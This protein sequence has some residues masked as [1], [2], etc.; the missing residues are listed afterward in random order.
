MESNIILSKESS[1]EEIKS[2]F[3]AVLRLSQDDNEFPINLDE[4]WPLVYSEKSKAVRS[5]K[6][7][8]IEDID[9]QV[10]AQNGENLEEVDYQVLRKN[11]ENSKG[12]RPTN[13][14]HI[15]LS[16]MEFFI[17]RKVRPV[18]E[19]YRQ[20][21]HGV[22]KGQL[23]K[24]VKGDNA[25]G[26]TLEEKLEFISICKDGGFFAWEV[27]GMVGDLF[28][29]IRSLAE[30]RTAVNLINEK[31]IL[32]NR[33]LQIVLSLYAKNSGLPSVRTH[34]E[35]KELE[36]KPQEIKLPPLGTM[37]QRR[38]RVSTGTTVR[39]MTNL[40]R[41][42]GY[43]GIYARE[44][45]EA[46]KDVGFVRRI[47]FNGSKRWEWSLTANG[48][49]FGR[50]TAQRN[51]IAIRPKWLSSKFDGLMQTLGYSK[52]TRKGVQL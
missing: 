19:V 21:F 38:S 50:N 8:F 32:E 39:S 17:A 41:E 47:D 46:L 35:I 22:A 2:Y 1:S 42:R 33:V 30:L 15:S 6:E 10:L 45:M 20:V 31:Q 37:K 48:M 28:D 16:C 18:F 9:Y 24:P 25:G 40:L 5:L 11:A 3:H 52:E 36:I 43:Q 44:V 49:D 27:A 34:S 14:Y 51:G 4:V 13:V 12:G 26:H 23:V 7:N 29:G